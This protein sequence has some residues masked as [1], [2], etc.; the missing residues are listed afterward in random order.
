MT[1]YFWP[2]EFRIN[3]LA[4]ELTRRNHQISVLTGLPNYPSG[5]W[6]QGYSL[7]SVGK[8]VIEG[9]HI[10]RVPHFPRYKGKGWQLI[11]N[12]LS[13]A[14]SSSIFGIL[15]CRD[16]Y[17]VIFIFEPS[18]FTI[19]IPGAIL[20][21]FKHIP[22]L[23]W[24]QDLWP[25]SLTATGAVNSQFIINV[26]GKMVKTIYKQCDRVLVQSK[27]FIEPVIGA[28][29]Y[30][31]RIRYFP[32]WA[33]DYYHPVDIVQCSKEKSE[34]PDGFCVMFAGNFGTAQSLDTIIEAA[35]KLRDIKD[36]NWILIGDGR[37]R[38]S[39]QEQ[40]RDNKL[41]DTIHFLGRKPPE[42]MPRYFAV[43]DVLLVTLR[44]EPIFSF[45]IPSKLQTYLACGRPIVAALDGEGARIV[46]ESD[47]G[48]AV[49][50]GDSDGLAS[51]VRNIYNLSCEQRNEMGTHGRDYYLRNF[52]RKMLVDQL[53]GWMKDLV[54][55]EK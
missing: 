6:Y 1:Q 48:I 31:E 41:H 21:R 14:F 4:E 26:V 43:A 23:F 33:E 51:A 20:R 37:E 25:E 17:D 28:G 18:P 11:L 30:S 9:I 39:I 32:N 12:Y 16:K 3:D 24:V 44:S 53:D 45:T 40:V 50:A 2:E 22:M 10:Y 15:W 47:A 19:G 35:I 7:K 54:G 36:L 46:D 42:T 55:E 29:A 52:D 5:E 38:N 49:A 34:L 13:F 8:E 27:A